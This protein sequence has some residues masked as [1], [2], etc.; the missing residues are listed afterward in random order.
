[1]GACMGK[2]QTIQANQKLNIL[3]V[4]ATG[5]LG[6]LITKHS[7]ANPKLQVNILVRDPQK[8]KELVTEV[9]TAGGRVIQ[10]D[11]SQPET[12]RDVTKGMHTVISAVS[13]FDEKTII[14]GQTALVK[15]S[16][17]NGVKRFVPSDFGVNYTKF[18][19][20]ELN[21]TPIT[22]FKIK[23]NEYL[24]T[25]PIKTLHFWTGAL[26]E[27]FFYFQSQGFSYWGD[28]NHKYDFTSF[29][30][31]AKVVAAAVAREDLTGDV[32][33]VG[34][35]LTI[36]EFADIYNRVRGTNVEPKKAGS[37]S[38]L[39]KLYE[40][41]KS[42]GDAMS[43]ALLGL[44]LIIYDDRAKFDKNDNSKFAEVN[45]TFLKEFLKQNP[46]VKLP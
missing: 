34:N 42:E 37:L 15:D 26:L 4:G 11:L 29:E 6:A 5:H 27:T 40:Q 1:M 24:E 25:V 23:F 36:T 39:R 43:V 16:L 8:N 45:E 33:F 14:G 44:S 32:V 10:G 19:K 22:G 17:R 30:D 31:T 18:S 46:S 28:I 20:D 3:I 2:D 38:D 41:K 9:E 7:L 12:L 35:E 21:L 13:S